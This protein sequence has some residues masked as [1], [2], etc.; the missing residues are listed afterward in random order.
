MIDLKL[1][2]LPVTLGQLKSLLVLLP[3]FTVLIVSHYRYSILILH[4]SSMEMYLYPNGLGTAVYIIFR[5]LYVTMLLIGLSRDAS[6]LDL[7]RI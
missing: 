3:L 7:V 6:N 2:K 5:K 4:M 1:A